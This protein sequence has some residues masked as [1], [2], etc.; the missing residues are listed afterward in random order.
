[1]R[2]IWIQCGLA[3]VVWLCWV[4]HV[5]SH[6]WDLLH[7][8]SAIVMTMLA[9]S[10]VA[11]STSL[12]GGAVAFPVLTKVLHIDSNT[13][14]IFSL[15]IQSVGM[16]A[17][18]LMIGLNRIPIARPILLP[19]VLAG[20]CGIILGLFTVG[21]ILAGQHV[22]YLFSM[23][24][25]SVA[26]ILLARQLMPSMSSEA[27]TPNP[28]PLPVLVFGG[29]IGGVLSGLIG[30]GIDFIAFTLMVFVGRYPL[31]VA[32]ATSVVIMALNA[33]TGFFALLMF[34]DRF[35]GE[36]VSYWLAAVPV[37]VVG[38]PLGALAC[39][40][41]PAPLVLYFLLLLIA[42]EVFS[43]VAILGVK[44]G[45][46]FSGVTVAVAM[47]I[48]LKRASSRYSQLKSQA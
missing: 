48:V 31:K 30:T 43:T 8:Q 25:L 12:G 5:G 18:S 27:V 39:R 22:K 20:A 28:I 40:Y 16:G 29:L 21:P 36:V 13:A 2:A 44:W 19:F 33:I 38:A 3:A 17:A 1:M 10:F 14:L 23:F 15:A 32:T 47:L 6:A 26:L 7:Q 37:V 24:A 9:G 42:V 4:W 11:G 35:T 46:L 34:S 45:Y 41:L